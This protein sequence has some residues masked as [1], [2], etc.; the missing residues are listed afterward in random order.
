MQ[1]GKPLIMYIFA[2]YIFYLVTLFQNSIDTPYYNNISPEDFRNYV[3]YT[4][5]ESIKIDGK[6]D[7]ASWEKAAFSESF[8]DIEGLQKPAPLYDTKVKMLWDDDYLYIGALLK[9]PNIWATYTKRESVIFHEND[10]EIFID[11]NGDTHNYYEIEVNALNTIWDLLLTKSYRDGG[12]PMTSWDVEGMK[13]AVY[14]K[15]TINEPED[16][17]EFWSVEF[18][19]P[20]SSLKEYTTE[21]RK[22]KDGEQWRINFSRVQWK[23]DIIDEQYKKQV[24][25]KTRKSYPEFNWVWSPQEVIDMHRPETWGYLQFSDTSVGTKQVPFKFNKDELCKWYLRKVYFAQRQYF[26]QHRKFADDINLLGINSQFCTTPKFEI[27]VNDKSYQANLSCK[28]CS[29]KWSIFKDGKI[30]T[31]K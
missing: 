24:N 10:F 17:D 28:L 30:V 13:S 31:G 8:I 27:I 6:L 18:A 14:L 11:P 15:G 23:L 9:E 19:L 1:S 7:D 12:K 20:W 29:W 22:P 2:Q 26:R 25:P 4:T 21:N 3:C 5:N 16:T